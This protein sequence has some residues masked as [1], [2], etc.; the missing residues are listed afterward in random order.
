LKKKTV[1]REGMGVEEKEKEE[2]DYYLGASATAG[3]VSAGLGG[4]ATFTS[5]FLSPP[6]T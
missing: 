5:S 1:L 2:K 4:S 6:P 3:A